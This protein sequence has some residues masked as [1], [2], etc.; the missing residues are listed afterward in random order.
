MGCKAFF[1]LVLVTTITNVNSWEFENFVPSYS[2]INDFIHEL[3]NNIK[4]VGKN[5]LQAIDFL[6][7]T[8]DEECNYVCKKG[9]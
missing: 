6:D 8:L 3:H 2:N 9:R 7:E 1:V 4:W 5:L